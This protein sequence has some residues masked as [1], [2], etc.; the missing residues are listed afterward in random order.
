M[1][2]QQLRPGEI[3]QLRAELSERDLAIVRQVA[4]LRLMSA[5]QLQAV[6]FGPM[7]HHSQSAATRACGRRLQRLT[8]HRLLVRTERRVGGVR[9]GSA[10]YCYGLGPVGQ[11]V[12]NLEGPRRR[13][14]EPSSIFVR[15]TLAVGQLVVDLTLA[16]QDGN[17]DLLACQA[18]PRCWRYFSGLAG[19]TVLRPDLF[20]A[21]GVG[22]LEH[23]WFCEIDRATEGLPVVGR[24]C[25]LYEAYYRSGREQAEHGVFPRVCWIVPSEKRAKDLAQDIAGDRRLTDGL[26]AVT[27]G[28]RAISVL[29]GAAS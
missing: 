27:T 18:E 23:R 8:G 3:E 7:K 15:H 20:L 17:L 12:L 16:S 24:K 10:S 26:F 2:R 1:T 5:R 22:D 29:S 14:K 21:V 25:R 6:H 19:A 4:D 13:F 11:R 28:E 9:A